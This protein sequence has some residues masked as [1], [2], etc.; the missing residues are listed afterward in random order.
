MTESTAT[1][2]WDRAQF[3]Q[4]PQLPGEVIESDSTLQVLR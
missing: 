2:S 1:R 4:T 3:N